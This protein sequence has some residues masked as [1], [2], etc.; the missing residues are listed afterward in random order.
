MK[1]IVCIK[2]VPASSNV[3]IDPVTGVLIRDGDNVKMNPYDLF[4]L[5]AA[6]ELKEKLNAD[7]H[8]ITMGPD[9]AIS[10]LKEAI[11]M[12]A[13]RGTIISDRKFAGAD[14]LATAYTLSQL[15]ELIGDFDLIICGKQTTDGDTAQVGPEIAENLIVPHVPYVKEF[16]KADEKSLVI[17]SVYDQ[18]DEI[19]KVKLPA[20]VTIEKD[21]N[22]PRL[23]SF[24]R[25]QNFAKE[26]IRV[27]RFNDLKDQNENNYGLKGSPTQ[28]EE[29]FSPDKSMVTQKFVGNGEK[30]SESLYKVLKDNQFIR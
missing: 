12:G 11:F 30:L 3:K 8:A 15:I 28:V 26:L 13:D 17:R 7:V 25:Q 20:L 14:V 18:Y 2:Q 19:V 16:I 24:K 1:I 6:F 21:A 10:V 22:V 4:A 29:M 27:V 9:S 5:E 23:P